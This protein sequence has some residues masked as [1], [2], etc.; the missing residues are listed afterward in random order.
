M[1]VNSS[2]LAL[3]FYTYK[4]LI[5]KE[6]LG[7]FLGGGSQFEI[8]VLSEFTDLLN[9]NKMQIDEALRYYMSYFALP[10]EG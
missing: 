2:K 6:K 7:E 10:G 9:F 3:F 1:Q 5:N 4:E 8:K